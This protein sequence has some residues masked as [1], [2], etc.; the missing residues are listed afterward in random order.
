MIYISASYEYLDNEFSLKDIYVSSEFQEMY[1]L[2]KVSGFI[3]VR[4]EGHV[5]DV[6]DASK[7]SFY[8]LIGFSEVRTYEDNDPKALALFLS[9]KIQDVDF[10]HKDADKALYNV[11]SS[12]GDGYGSASV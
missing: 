6:V 7:N 2:S 9:Q 1:I 12:F 11:I 4:V 3:P 8:P 10:S 5:I